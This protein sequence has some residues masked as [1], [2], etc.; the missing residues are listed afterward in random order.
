MSEQITLQVSDRVV[1]QAAHVA[2]QSRRR[3]EE[4]LVEWLEQVIT[5]LPV[6]AL[7]DEEVLALTELQLTAEQQA[8]LSDL[9]AQNRENTLDTEGRRQLDELMRIYE[10]GLLRKAQ[11]LRVAVQRGLREPLQP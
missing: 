8:T 7:S 1:N 9:L 11:A 4:V 6:E 2:A 3:I 10:H 5:E